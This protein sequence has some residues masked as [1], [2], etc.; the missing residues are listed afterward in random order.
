VEG[1]VGFE[2]IATVIGVVSGTLGVIAFFLPRLPNGRIINAIFVSVIT[3]LASYAT[4][5]STR[6]ARLNSV[7][8]GATI[9]NKDIQMDYTSDGYVEAAMTFL[10]KNKD[11]YPDAYKRA[12]DDYNSVMRS[13]HRGQDVVDLEYRLKAIVKAEGDLASE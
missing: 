4:Y 2:I 6:F 11:I 1:A 13:S 3:I 10:E 5:Q 7:A 12:F 8:R 9:L